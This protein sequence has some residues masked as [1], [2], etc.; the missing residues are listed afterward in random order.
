MYSPR[1]LESLE[2]QT[3]KFKGY[4]KDD[5]DSTFEI[6]RADYE[7]LYK[8]NIALKD[9]VELLD[10]LV[11]QYKTVE[12]TM[13]NTLLIAQT[14]A[15]DVVK[16]A[17]EQADG[18]IEDARREAEGLKMNM[19]GDIGALENRRIQIEQDLKAFVFKAKALLKTEQDV[20]DEM[21]MD[22]MN[23]KGE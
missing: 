14:T 11:Q 5:V 1:D 20:L 7:T 6:I 2:F 10:N 19:Q 22:F 17:K 4:D 23:A 13:Q 8:E 9:K 15:E 18:I 12:E 21:T 16:N 3:T